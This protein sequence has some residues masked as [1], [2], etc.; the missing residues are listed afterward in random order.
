MNVA[1]DFRQEVRPF[2]L[3][4]ASVCR[5]L[6]ALARMLLKPSDIPPS[7]SSSSTM[8]GFLALTA[9]LLTA[10]VASPVRH[11]TSIANL[12]TA[13]VSIRIGDDSG[14]QLTV[15]PGYPQAPEFTPVISATPLPTNGPAPSLQD[16][17]IVPQDTNTFT[18]QSVIFPSMFISYAGIGI[19]ATTPT[20]GQLVLRGTDNA[21]V[22][23][24]QTLSSGLTVN[25]VIPAINKVLRA[26]FTTTAD[27]DRSSPYS[28]ATLQAGAT[29][30][31]FEMVVIA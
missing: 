28:V 31:I 18:I 8:F 20:H 12:T 22:F 6:L 24:L 9:L 19:S 3:V 4:L 10:A 15:D 21:A 13:G 11:V 29:S 16:W 27:A 23:S 14:F 5:E 7:F 25:I 26:W 17:I 1:S 30:Q 2:F